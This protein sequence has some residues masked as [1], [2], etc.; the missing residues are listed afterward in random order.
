MALQP[1]VVDLT[2]D[3]LTVNRNAMMP[4]HS[5]LFLVSISCYLISNGKSTS[6]IRKFNLK[7]II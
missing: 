3:Q 6:R 5:P 7:G 2:E 4:S 1:G